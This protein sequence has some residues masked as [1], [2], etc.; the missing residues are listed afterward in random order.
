MSKICNFKLL[1]GNSLFV[2]FNICLSA[3]QLTFLTDT[4]MLQWLL[5]FH[6][7]LHAL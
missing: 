6:F 3:S 7:P 5:T 1:I 2:F 4:I